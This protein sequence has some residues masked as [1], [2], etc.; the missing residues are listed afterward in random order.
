VIVRFGFGHAGIAIT[1]HHQFVETNHVDGRCQFGLTHRGHERS[2]LFRFETVERLAFF[3]QR[4]ILQV[5]LFATGATHEHGVHFLFVIHR[6]CR[7]TLGCLVVG[8]RMDSQERETISHAARVSARGKPHRARSQ[9]RCDPCS[10]PG[11]NRY[12]SPVKFTYTC[13][14]VGRRLAIIIGCLALTACDTGDGK[15]LREPTGTLPPPTVPLTTTELPLE[16]VGTLPSLPLEDPVLGE[17][18]A[19]ATPLAGDFRLVAPWLDGGNIDTRHTCDG[20]G[21]SPAL[22][23]ADVPAGT[24]EL[25]VSVIN[26]S[27]TSAMPT[28]HWVI[29]GIAPT[30]ISLIEANIP[31]GAIQATT[32][33]DEI[34]FSAPCPDAGSGVHEYRF[35]IYALNQ[36]VE[37]A[38][39]TPAEDLLDFVQAV[40]I[41][42]TDVI[43][44]VER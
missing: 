19:L 13:V 10:Q 16:G 25:A 20:E 1:K 28:V 3:A 15:T 29:A 26:D 42:A 32:S 37:L 8:M 44:T 36:Q 43:G 2:F 27:V 33:F 17:Q 31:L 35:T 12:Q 24:V 7:C 18:P 38:D 22:S 14:P 11:T 23:W 21:V 5:A 34:G 39:S 6:Q 4:R 40:S 30:D 41:A 9:A